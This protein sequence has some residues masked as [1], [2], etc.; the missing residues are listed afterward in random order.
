M[1]QLVVLNGAEKGTRIQL[2]RANV[3]IGRDKSCDLQLR[4]S[5]VSRH[6]CWVEQE[7]GEWYARDLGSRNG[8]WL[9]GRRIKLPT[10]L[11]AGMELKVGHVQLRV[12]EVNQ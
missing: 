5:F 9:N 12:E 6:H 11:E 3:L 7:A 4:D 8:T 2:D 10:L 1:L